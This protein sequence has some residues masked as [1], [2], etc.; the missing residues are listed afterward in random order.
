MFWATP[1]TLHRLAV[2]RPWCRIKGWGPW[3]SD[4]GI[5]VQDCGVRGAESRA[6]GIG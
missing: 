1:Y 5:R 2:S 4:L 3:V 6:L